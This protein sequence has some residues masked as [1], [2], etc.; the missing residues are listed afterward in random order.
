MVLGGKKIEHQL[1]DIG[2]FFLIVLGEATERR[3]L[4]MLWRKVLFN[5]CVGACPT[6]LKGLSKTSGFLDAV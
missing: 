3:R 2:S 1:I 6:M 5:G 4:P